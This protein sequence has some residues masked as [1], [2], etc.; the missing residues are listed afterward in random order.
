VEGHLLEPRSDARRAGSDASA[1]HREVHVPPRAL[2]RL[3]PPIRPTA[4]RGTLALDLDASGTLARPALKTRGSLV[5]FGPATEREDPRGIDLSLDAEYDAKGGTLWVQAD[6]RKRAVLRIDSRWRGDLADLGRASSEQSPVRGELDVEFDEFP[7]VVIPTFRD[8]KIRGRVS[9]KA[10]LDGFG[11]NARFELGLL[12][13]RL[14]VDRMMLDRV[15]ARVRTKGERI[16]IETA[17]AGAGGKAGA[18]ITTGI[19]WG[20]R[21]V[22]VIDQNVQGS[23]FAERLQ[24]AALKPLV[25]GSVSELD[26]RLDARVKAEIENGSPRLAGKATLTG[27]VLQLP[28]IGQRFHDISAKV[29][30]SPDRIRVDDLVARGTSGRLKAHAEAKLD[31]VK[32]VSVS[33][34]VRIKE[35]EKL[36]ITLEGESI[37][38]AWGS[39][40]A[41]YQSDAANSRQTVNVDVRRFVIE[42]PEAPPQGIQPLDQDPHV[43]VGFRRGDRKFAVVPLQPLEEVDP[44]PGEP[45]TT[46]VVVNLGSVRVVKGQQAEVALGGRIRATMGER[47]DVRG[48]IETRRGTLDISGKEFEIER[49]SVSF[50]GGEPSDPKISAVARYDSPAGYT[51]YAEYTGTAQAGKLRLSSDPPLSQDEILTL[52]LFGTPDG[53]FGGGGNSDSLSTAVS[54]AGGTAAKGLNRAL[55]DVTELD[56]SARIDTSTGAPRPEL[57]V[58]LTPRVAARVTQAIGEPTPGQSP[59]RTFLT[60]EFRFARAWSLSTMVGDR[61]ASALDLVWRNRY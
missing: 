50:T 5:R 18:R 17:I 54:V 42:L 12:T 23:M 53:S 47:L 52:L 37:G 55:S 15:E 10:R 38:D 27:G 61:G 20:A 56:V 28:A 25:E 40:V 59:D 43:R 9:G 32:P 57:V 8:R 31:G 34:T 14:R 21:L 24:L 11:E 58:Q 13:E 33:A 48:Q 29:S 45:T 2:E 16:E 30:V 19:D 26:G 35:D 7:V 39:I 4:V 51:V 46:T 49:G 6:G 3:P 22:P 1:L 36:P 60:V 41:N 44:S